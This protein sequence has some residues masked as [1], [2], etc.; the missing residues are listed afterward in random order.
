MA[1]FESARS[2]YNTSTRVLPDIYAL[3]QGRCAPLGIVSIYDLTRSER[4]TQKLLRDELKAHKDKGEVDLIIRGN[5]IV[6]RRENGNIGRALGSSRIMEA[7]TPPSDQ[8]Q[9]QS[10]QPMESDG[11]N[12]SS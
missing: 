3:A 12:T 6:K 2:G 10:N 1:D 7:C 4:E 9:P 8:H 11:N 5:R